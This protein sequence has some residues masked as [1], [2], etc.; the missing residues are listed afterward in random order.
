MAEVFEVT[1]WATGVL[2][3]MEGRF[4]ARFWVLPD[5]VPQTEQVE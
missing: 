2:Q 5:I 4:K 3:D 1:I